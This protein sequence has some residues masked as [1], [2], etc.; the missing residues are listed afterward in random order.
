MT[1]IAK[2]FAG[3]GA[4]HEAHEWLGKRTNMKKA[5]R[6]C[7]EPDWLVWIAGRV[8]IDNN[9]L[10]AAVCDALE[11]VSD[12]HRLLPQS[13]ELVRLWLDG[14][15]P[16]KHIKHA[17]WDSEVEHYLLCL[18]VETTKRP[19]IEYAYAAAGIIWA[20]EDSSDLMKPEVKKAMCKA[21]RKR[22]PFFDVA[23]AFAAK[24]SYNGK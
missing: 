2:R 17:S 1:T 5:W 24:E 12:N 8:G 4:C 13:I 21:I 14:K 19:S 20:L 16:I 7:P 6:E 23:E 9:L 15:A 22:I 18:V 10:I 3:L 11:V